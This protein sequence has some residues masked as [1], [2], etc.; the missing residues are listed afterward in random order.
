[1]S[2][3]RNGQLLNVAVIGMGNRGMNLTEVI[4]LPREN[5]RVRAICDDYAPHLER[6]RALVEAHYGEVPTCYADYEDM[7]RS[8]SVDCVFVF[9]AWENHLPA[10]LFAMREHIPV[11]VEVGGAYSVHECWQLIDT[12]EATGTPVMLLE[13]CCYGRTE[14]MLLRMLREGLFGELVHADGG[15]LHDLR[16]EIATGDLRHHYRHRNY[17]IRNSENYPTHELGPIA[18]FFDINRGNRITAL[19]SWSSGAFGLRDWA[20]RHDEVSELTKRANFAQGDIV[21]TNLK[22]AGGQTITLTLDT[23]LP[24]WYCRGLALHGTRGIYQEENHSIFLDGVD[25][26]KHFTWRKEW[27]N[28]DRFFEDYEHPIWTRYQEEG[29][30]GGHDG[31]DWLVFSAFLDAVRSGDPMPIDVYDMATWMAVTSLSEDSL[32]IGGQPLPF[33]D[34]TRGQWLLRE[35][36]V[37]APV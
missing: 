12:Y 22:L 10:T 18:K 30:R 17:L 29:V 6:G 28:A 9:S 26:D 32:A 5:V 4:L 37:F 16:T 33:P 14:L 1:M 24:R 3:E 19:A 31:M 27:G 23:S 20:E 11:A 13:N 15:Y 34:F 8:E 7:I 35:P 36:G 21:K 2:E 25:D